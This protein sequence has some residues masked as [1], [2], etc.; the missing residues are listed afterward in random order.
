MEGY[1]G[2]ELLEELRERKEQI[3]K[4]FNLLMEDAKINGDQTTV[5]KL[6]GDK[7]DGKV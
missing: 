7:N 2:G 1:S 3:G 6:F 4:A 5:D